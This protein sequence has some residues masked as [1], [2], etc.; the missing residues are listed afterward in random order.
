MIQQRARGN[1]PQD[2]FG[3]GGSENRELDVNPLRSIASQELTLLVDRYGARTGRFRVRNP[4]TAARTTKTRFILRD[5]DL[6]I[7][8]YR[9]VRVCAEQEGDY[10]IS[11]MNR[12]FPTQI[13]TEF[14]GQ[15]LIHPAPSVANACKPAPLARWGIRRRCGIARAYTRYKVSS[16]FIICVG[17]FFALRAK[18]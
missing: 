14:N 2:T 4:A 9:C 1:I 5:Y 15:L 8:C 10:A 12:G 17:Y 6:C 3:N 13:T 16:G 18:K 11:V 7:S